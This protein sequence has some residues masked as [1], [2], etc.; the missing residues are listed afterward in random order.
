MGPSKL[1]VVL[2]VSSLLIA[3]AAWANDC[4]LPGPDQVIIYEQT[5]R[6]GACAVLGA[7]DYLDPSAFGLPDN[8]I[9]AMDVGANLR[10]VLYEHSWFRGRQAHYEGGWNYGSLGNV[11]NKTSSIEIFPM[12]GGPAATWYLGN[13]PSNRESFWSND[14]QGLAN[15]GANWF[16]VKG[17]KKD[18]TRI[19]KVPLS[20]DLGSSSSAGLL[21][22]GIPPVLQNIGYGHFGD[23]DVDKRYGFLFVPAEASSKKPRIAV[24]SPVD[25]RFLSSFELSDN[26]DRGASWLAIRP[27]EET[28]WVSTSNLSEGNHIREYEID[29]GRLTTDGQLVLTFRRQVTLRDRDGGVLNLQSIQ[30]GVFD[31]DGKLYISTGY[32]SHYYVRVFVIEDATDTATLQAHS[33]NGYGP[34]NFE[35]G[36]REE[37]YGYIF[38]EIC[39]HLG[40]EAEG[41]DWLD[42]RGLNVPG[43]PDG[44]LHLVMIDNDKDQDD[45]YLKHYSY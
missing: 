36:Y 23:P 17:Y 20:Y 2:V 33:G 4:G 9:S 1:S 18:N 5:D 29:W 38:G 31:P 35:A 24:F 41:L 43:I 45:L 13:Y 27:R 7:G 34:F 40:D 26:P 14:S 8:S 3:Y 21:Q 32:D 15:D 6:G 10:A 25:L 28:L 44:Q 19:F 42:V 30:G 12:Q 11:D 22:T 37:C 39:I 16:V